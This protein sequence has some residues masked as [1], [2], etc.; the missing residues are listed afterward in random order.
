VGRGSVEIHVEIHFEF[1]AGQIR[2]LVAKYEEAF[3]KQDWT[4]VAA[5]FT[6]DGVSM[7]PHDGTFH[8]RQAIEKQYAPRVMV[9]VEH[10]GEFLALG[11]VFGVAMHNIAVGMPPYVRSCKA[12]PCSHQKYQSA[13][14]RSPAAGDQEASPN[15]V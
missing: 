12:G 11:L 13:L 1:R 3:N 8:G 2:G 4:A 5:L 15:T 14:R 6:E 7:T 10:E 9:G